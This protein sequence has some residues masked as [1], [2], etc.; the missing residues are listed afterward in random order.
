M[1]ILEEKLYELYKLHPKGRYRNKTHFPLEV[2]TDIYGEVIKLGTDNLINHFP[3]YFNPSTVFY[4]LGSGL[5]KMV[6]HIGLQ[7][8]IKKS[9]GIEFSKERYEAS[10]F[11]KEKFTQ[12]TN[13]I[14]FINQSYFN[15]TF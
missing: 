6:I 10:L 13:N 2:G 5:G 3:S 15:S 4:D 12:D 14:H 8:N 9:I 7:C 11:L 1:E